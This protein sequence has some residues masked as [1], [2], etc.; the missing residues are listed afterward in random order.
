MAFDQ[1]SGCN[2]ELRNTHLCLTRNKSVLTAYLESD[3]GID[4]EWQEMVGRRRSRDRFVRAPDV[5]DGQT[6][7]QSSQL[8]RAV[9]PMNGAVKRGA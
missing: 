6:T 5:P 4:Q 7:A 3:V 9:E 8:G 2:L 1:T